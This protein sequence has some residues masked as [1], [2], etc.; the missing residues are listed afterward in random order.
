M[1][2]LEVALSSVPIFEY[3]LDRLL[4][5]PG[6]S[7]HQGRGEALWSQLITC[8]GEASLVFTVVQW[9]HYRTKVKDRIQAHA[10][11]VQQGICGPQEPCRLL[12]SLPS[13]GDV[14]RDNQAI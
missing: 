1:A 6:L 5:R 8:S 10:A 9:V 11:G 13:C 4:W 7:G 12:G 14:P 3:L 2:M